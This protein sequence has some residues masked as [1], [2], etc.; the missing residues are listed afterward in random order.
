MKTSLKI[1]IVSGWL[2]FN[3]NLAGQDT[4]SH[5]TIFPSGIS[6]GSGMGLYSV[7]DEYISKEKYSGNLPYLNLEWVWFHY[8]GAYRLEFEYQNSTKISN[9]LKKCLFLFRTFFSVF[10]L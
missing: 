8:K 6:L 1:L 2:L 5:K 4:I 10:L 7:K 3:L 9:V